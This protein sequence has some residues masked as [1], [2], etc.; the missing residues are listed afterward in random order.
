MVLLKRLMQSSVLAVQ[1]HFPTGS[2]SQLWYGLL[3]CWRLLC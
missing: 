3:L 2:C 1:L